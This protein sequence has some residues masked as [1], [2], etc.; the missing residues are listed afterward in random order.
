MRRLARRGVRTF[1]LACKMGLLRGG[2]TDEQRMV[3]EGW[4]SQKD[5]MA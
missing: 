1:R 5:G 3:T 4:H 2:P